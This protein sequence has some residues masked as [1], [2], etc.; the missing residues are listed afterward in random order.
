MSVQAASKTRKAPPPEPPILVSE[1]ASA[2]IMGVSVPTFRKWTKQGLIQRV[3]LP[4]G[5]VRN[6]Y[7]RQDLEALAA[8]FAAQ[9]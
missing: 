9:R 7:R 8:S 3:D 2:A 1:V 6:L 4:G 5:T